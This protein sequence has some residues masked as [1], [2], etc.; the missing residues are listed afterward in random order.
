MHPRKIHR[1]ESGAAKESFDVAKL[2][3]K[4]LC[5]SALQHNL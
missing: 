1:I 3:E 2:W 5:P 4:L